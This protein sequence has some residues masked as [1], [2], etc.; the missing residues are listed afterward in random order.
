[1]VSSSDE[2]E[3]AVSAR[4]VTPAS[5]TAAMRV[6]FVVRMVSP[7]GVSGR[8]PVVPCRRVVRDRRRR[9]MGADLRGAGRCCD[10]ST[11]ALAANLG[12]G[13]AHARAHRPRRWPHHRHLAVHPARA[14]GRLLR[15]RRRGGAGPSD[16][17]ARGRARRRPG[18][19]PVRRRD[20]AARAP[21]PARP[22]AA[23]RRDARSGRPSATH[24]PGRGPG[25]ARRPYL[26]IAG[27]VTS[28]TLVTLVGTRACS[29]CWACRRT[30]CA[31]RASSCWRCSAS[32]CSSRGSRS[33][34]SAR[35]RG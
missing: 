1:M 3:Q 29:T 34:W 4:P 17:V 12:H 20:A 14:A 23:T 21:R 35:S 31:G 6:R 9:R 24:R 11:G 27:L 30:C 19:G 32:G 26:V 13:P 8:Y 25:D 7:C 15:R 28:F 18:Q 22:G 2:L 16:G 33:C 5:R 10:P